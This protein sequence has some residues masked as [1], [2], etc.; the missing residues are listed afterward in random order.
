MGQQ[1]NHSSQ[2]VHESQVVA[3]RTSFTQV[4]YADPKGPGA[5]SGRER[6]QRSGHSVRHHF[7]GQGKVRHVRVGR[8]LNWVKGLECGGGFSGLAT[9]AF[10]HQGIAGLAVKALPGQSNTKLTPLCCRPPLGGSRLRGLVAVVPKCARS[11]SNHRWCMMLL[12]CGVDGLPVAVGQ[13]HSVAASAAPSRTESRCGA[14]RQRVH[15][16]RHGPT[17]L[18]QQQAHAAECVCCRIGWRRIPATGP[19]HLRQIAERRQP[20]QHEQLGGRLGAHRA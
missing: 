9:Q 15:G 18:E 6:A 5:V 4:L 13:E 20:R 2:V 1:A 14:Q 8:R 10:S 7:V 19:Q 12:P 16:P 17:G 3:G 11:P